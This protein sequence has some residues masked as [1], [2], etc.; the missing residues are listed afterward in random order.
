M[1]AQ[2]H[3]VQFNID[4]FVVFQALFLNDSKLTVKIENDN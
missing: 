1:Q 4:L 3:F 2:N